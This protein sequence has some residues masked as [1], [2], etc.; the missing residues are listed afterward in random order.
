[1]NEAFDLY[2]DMRQ[3]GQLSARTYS[4]LIRLA[5]RAHRVL[6]HALLGEMR[7][8]AVEPN[9]HNYLALFDTYKT[10]RDVDGV[11]RAWQD[12]RA[13]GTRPLYPAVSTV[14][15][16]LAKTGDISGTEALLQEARD[17][18]L[19]PTTVCYNSILD[20]CQNAGDADAAF[21]ILSEMRA[22]GMVP[23]VISYSSALG[24]L[25]AAH[26]PAADRARLVQEMKKD[27][28]SQNSLFL[29]RYVCYALGMQLDQSKILGA[30]A[31]RE[32]V[33]GLP[34]EARQEAVDAIQEGKA[35][36]VE[37]T[38]LVKALEGILESLGESPR[39]AAVSDQQNSGD[40]VKVLAKD[41]AGSQIEYFW[42]RISGKT[43]W[44]HPGCQL[45]LTIPSA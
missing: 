11:K 16:T 44:E 19:S 12:M 3:R 30:E 23:D 40:W 26:R 18:G 20:A 32:Q 31:L 1:M 10:A 5:G 7:A 35:T 29:E 27:G 43:Q 24:A 9:G 37:L 42:D 4:P 14:M 25:A 21:R 22:A 15:S 8:A 34:A 36:Q 33:Q 2:V 45:A 28:V 38:K 17:L 6:A 39:E 13:A 41:E